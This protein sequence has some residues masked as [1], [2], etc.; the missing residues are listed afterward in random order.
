MSILGSLIQPNPQSY[1]FATTGSSPGPSSLTSPVVVIPDGT[2]NTTLALNAT[3]TAGASAIAVN[4]SAGVPGGSGVI[5]VG[6]FGTT[7]RAGVLSNVGDLQIGLNSASP[8]VIS[9]D[10]QNTHQLI[11]GDESA[12]A[13]AS[14]QTNVPLIVRDTVNDPS[15]LNGFGITVDSA[16]TATIGNGVASGGTLNIGSSQALPSTLV[17]S[18]VPSHGAGNYIQVKGASGQV[19]LF[20]SGAQGAGGVCYMFPDAVPPTASQLRLGSDSSNSDVV[21]I[22]SSAVTVGTLGIPP[23]YPCSTARVA[24]APGAGPTFAHGQATYILPISGLT[25]G[26]YSMMVYPVPGSAGPTD[27]NTLGACFSTMFIMKGGQCVYGG[28]GQNR[29]GD[30]YSFPSSGLG[31]I[32]FNIAVAANFYLGIDFFQLSG[33][34]PGV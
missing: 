23:V 17:V 15:S 18:D 4:G 21:L 7:Y 22:S 8:P 2:G 32:T 5:T 19:P 9:Y 29:I 27:L 33:P 11:L 3:G 24:L 1:F 26:M 25:D 20:V 28:V 10:S 31:S 34:V 6:G 14:V 13:T 30:V 12:V 16:T